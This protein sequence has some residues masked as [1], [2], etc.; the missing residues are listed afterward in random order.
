MI[1]LQESGNHCTLG[2]K[3]KD[4]GV[5]IPENEHAKLFTP[6]FKSRRNIM[7]NINNNGRGLGL[8]ISHRICRQMDG[9]LKI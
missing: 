9:E 2:V 8:S 4:Y 6:F 5:G 1:E 3:I 7:E